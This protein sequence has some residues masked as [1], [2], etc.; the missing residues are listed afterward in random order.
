MPSDQVDTIIGAQVE[1]TGSLR[2]Q[3]AIH[4]HGHITGDV[5]S[6]T[7]VLVGETAVVN[8]PITAKQVEVAGQ[9]HGN[10]TAEQQIELQPKS[11]VKGD[12]ITKILSIKPGANFFGQSKMEAAQESTPT[13][14]GHNPKRKPRLELE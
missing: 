6:D 10:I 8:G 1:L 5:T 11:I 14:E 2:N 3:G 9:V 7:M 4:I 13:E 12:L